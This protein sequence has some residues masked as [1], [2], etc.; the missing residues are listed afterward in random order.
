MQVQAAL[1]RLG[2]DAK[3]RNGVMSGWNELFDSKY[4]SRTLI[5]V[6][7]MFFQRV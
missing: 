1:V 5:G 3:D 2:T 6:M 7:M 4:F